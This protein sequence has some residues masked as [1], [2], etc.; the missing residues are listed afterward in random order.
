MA[1]SASMLQWSLTGGSERCFAI[2]LH[3]SNFVTSK[4]NK[5]SKTTNHR[6]INK[7]K[8]KLFSSKIKSYRRAWF[9]NQK[10]LLEG[11]WRKKKKEKKKPEGWKHSSK[12]WWLI[13][14]IIHQLVIIK[15]ET[16][17]RHCKKEQNQGP[18]WINLFEMIYW[19][20]H[21]WHYL[22]EL[23]KTAMTCS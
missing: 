2:S 19:P 21:L 7:D 1:S 8:I 20:K 14:F 10:V 18:V 13:R 12:R 16:R 6:S 22:G 11:K 4:T 17:R 15:K 3:K 5:Q 23:V 9:I